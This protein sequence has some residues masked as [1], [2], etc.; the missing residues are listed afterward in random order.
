MNNLIA[1]NCGTLT[2]QFFDMMPS[3][4]SPTITQ[5]HIPYFHS[6]LCD[7]AYNAAQQWSWVIVIDAINKKNLIEKIKTTIKTLEPAIWDTSSMVDD[8]MKN[9]VQNIIGCIFAQ[10]VRIP[11]ESTTIEYVGITEGSRRGFINAPIVNGRGDFQPLE[12]G[13]LETNQSFVDGVL[14]PW[15]II[16]NHE[17]LIARPPEKSI[18]ANIHLY[19]LAKFGTHESIIRNQMTFYDCVPINIMSDDLSY[20]STET[21]IKKVEFVYSNYGIIGTPT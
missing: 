10:A 20:S 14:R 12:I 16:L 5:G 3:S 4:N 13:F 9:S 15:N 2:P 21:S 17:G 18:K 1:T 8:T 7:W 6:L 19:Q 11:G